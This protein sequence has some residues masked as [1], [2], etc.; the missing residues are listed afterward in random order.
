MLAAHQREEHRQQLGRL[1]AGAAHHVEQVEVRQD[2]VALGH[3]TA[4][5]I[6]AALLA[7]DQAVVLHH[8]RRDVLEAD[9]RI[10]HLDAVALAQLL[11]HRGRAQRLNDRPALA[12]NLQQIHRQQ[13]VNPELVDELPVLVAEAA[14]IRVAIQD[15]DRVRA[16]GPRLRQPGVH[17]RRDRFGPVHLRKDGVP[18]RVVLQHLGLA[19]GDEAGKVAGAVA[20]HVVHQHG[21]PGVLDRLDI[22]QRADARV[23]GR[24]GIVLADQT[25]LDPRVEV[26]PPDTGNRGRDLRFDG[27]EPVRVNRA[28]VRIAHLVAVVLR[29]VVAGRDIDRAQRPCVGHAEGDDRGGHTAAAEVDGDAVAGQHLGRGRG[30]ILGPEALV[31]ADHSPARELGGVSRLQIVGKALGAATDV[32]EGIVLGD[33][34]PPAVGAKDDIAHVMLLFGR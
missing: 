17:V 5:R 27:L 11:Q 3:V 10:D 9:A 8:R 25:R 29:R 18:L 22:H 12:A 24:R 1:L 26:H 2:A 19:A 6:A 20:P 34:G 33:A 32:V 13:G 28:A 31:A 7:A 4:K 15:A 23:V 30:E 21:E 14:A 16:D